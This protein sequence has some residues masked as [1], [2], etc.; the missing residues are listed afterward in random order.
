MR[1]TVVYVNDSALMLDDVKRGGDGKIIGGRVV[2]G[3]W[4]M[5]LYG[6]T[7]YAGGAPVCQVRTIDEYAVEGNGIRGGYNAVIAVADK[8]REKEAV[9]FVRPQVTTFVCAPSACIVGDHKMDGPVVQR[10]HTG[11]VSCSKCG[12]LA[13]DVDN[14][15]GGA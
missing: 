4:D 1:H 13:F 8:I 3:G 7:M 12:A 9:G 11:S 2:N 14:F 5:A 10:G 15:M 6:N